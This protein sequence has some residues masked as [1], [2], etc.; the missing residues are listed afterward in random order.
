MKRLLLIVLPL[1]MSVGCSEKNPYDKFSEYGVNEKELDLEWNRTVYQDSRG[2]G[3]KLYTGKVYKTSITG[4]R[5]KDGNYDLWL[6]YKGQCTE[7]FRSGEWTWYYKDGGKEKR[8]TYFHDDGKSKDTNTTFWRNGQIKEEFY[9]VREK[10]KLEWI[11][12]GRYV[13]YYPNGQ[14]EYEEFYKNDK[15]VDGLYFYYHENG[16]KRTEGNFKDG[17]HDGKWVSWHENG[18]KNS[19]ST[20]KNL[21]KYGLWTTWWDNG[22]KAK[23]EE[24][25]GGKRKKIRIYE[26]GRHLRTQNGRYWDKQGKPITERECAFIRIGDQKERM[27]RYE[28]K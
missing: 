27:K 25:I 26:N 11:K 3:T 1:L 22:Q 13:S 7:G 23:E 21:V 4:K 19:E 24:Y 12:E 20:Y 14:L 2:D 5:D 10:G 16:Q 28:D 8:T 17:K 9:F 6:Y 18:Q 15:I